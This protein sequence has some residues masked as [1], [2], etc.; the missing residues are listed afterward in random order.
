MCKI[1]V[2][3]CKTDISCKNLGANTTCPVENKENPMSGKCCNE[4]CVKGS[5]NENTPYC[6]SLCKTEPPITDCNTISDPQKKYCC[7]YGNSSP[8]SAAICGIYDD[9]DDSSA[10]ENTCTADKETIDTFKY[11][12]S[13]WGDEQYQNSACKVS[14]EEV[15]NTTF[16][17]AI[18]GIKAGT[19]FKYPI[20]I[21]SDRYCTAEYTN[22]IWK[23]HMDAAVQAAKN[24]Y[25]KATNSI[26]N[27][28]ALDDA[29]GDK[30][31]QDAGNT[32]VAGET[33]TSDGKCKKDIGFTCNARPSNNTATSRFNETCS[34]SGN[35]C[36]CTSTTETRGDCKTKDKKGKCL[37]FNW[38]KAIDT[39]TSTACLG[40]YENGSCYSYHD[41]C[42]A[43]STWNGSSCI[44]TMCSNNLS[45][46]FDDQQGLI[47][48][49]INDA[50]KFKVDYNNEI[51]K[52]NVLISDRT[53][54]DNYTTQV[55]YNGGINTKIDVST[56][57]NDYAKQTQYTTVN[58][59]ASIDAT[60]AATNNGGKDYPYQVCSSKSNFFALPSKYNDGNYPNGGDSFSL[61]Y[62]NFQ[63]QHFTYYDFWNK[64]TSS[65]VNLEYSNDYSVMKYTGDI[66]E[67][68]NI[69]SDKTNAYVSH[70]RYA[71][72]DFYAYSGTYQLEN[73]ITNI[74]PNI[75]NR[76][77]NLFSLT[78]FTCTYKINNLIF[79]Q[80]GDPNNDKYGSIAFSYRQVSLT[81]P[82]PNRNPRENW[83]GKENLITSKGYEVYNTTKPLYQYYLDPTRMQSIRI[84]NSTHNYGS[85]DINNPYNSIFLNNV[86]RNW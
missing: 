59:K 66:L 16:P 21:N 8:E 49:A 38:T 67:A 50:N 2:T 1:P 45:I 78:P 22:D 37:V 31:P 12:I 29:C 40:S 84:Y 10:R 76:D 5:G 7:L 80:E 13:G 62:C 72:T 65:E 26:N 68:N 58:P 30:S 57:E 41:A 34:I 15:I 79:P 61:Q 70:G 14:C 17:K 85:Y 35:T 3:S 48:T 11:P 4:L 39:R 54:C 77:K 6:T 36:T 25:T 42:P 18:T 33:L 27:A 9:R 28:K 75:N 86:V 53:T 24:D 55:K 73:T 82:F 46:Y 51:F 23:V 20:K 74:G 43:K 47:S 44:K 69:P 64:K 83:Q 71:Y 63:T 52:I 60:I 19:G 81:D 32:C 56:P